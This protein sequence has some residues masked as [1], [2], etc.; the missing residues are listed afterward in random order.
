MWRL[1]LYRIKSLHYYLLILLYVLLHILGEI[2]HLL[3]QSGYHESILIR[4]IL[5]NVFVLVSIV[6]DGL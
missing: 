2:S 1:L 4:V 6:S 5:Y 3:F